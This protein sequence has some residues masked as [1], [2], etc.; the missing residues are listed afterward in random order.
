MSDVVERRPRTQKT[1][2]LRAEESALCYA[3]RLKGYTEQQIVE[4]TGISAATVHR[5]LVQHVENRVH[6][7]AEQYRQ[8][9]IDRLEHLYQRTMTK[10]D[11]G[12]LA[13]INTASNL[14][15]RMFEIS[16]LKAID[17]PPPPIIVM[18]PDTSEAVRQARQVNEQ[19]LQMIRESI[20][21]EVVED[22]NNNIS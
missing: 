1:R 11:N 13:A 5:R 21:G 9:L 8:M 10:V 15:S 6:P 17:A 20:P 4:E 7:Q 14:V 19:R 2:E 22:S 3:L 16:G 18:D 12:D